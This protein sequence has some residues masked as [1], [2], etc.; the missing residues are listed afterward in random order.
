MDIWVL[1][2]AYVPIADDCRAAVSIKGASTQSR[3]G[4][5]RT[6]KGELGSSRSNVGH[7]RS[8]SD[9]TVLPPGELQA[10]FFRR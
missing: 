3:Q 7:F 5:Y 8:E 2:N 6:D 9:L 4:A 10:Y 1:A